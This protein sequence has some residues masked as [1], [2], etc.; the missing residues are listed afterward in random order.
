MT[1]ASNNVQIVRRIDGR[2]LRIDQI[3]SVGPR[4]N[5]PKCATR[6]S[7]GVGST[8]TA[9]N[10]AARQQRLLPL[11]RRR[12]VRFGLHRGTDPRPPLLL[13]GHRGHAVEARALRVRV[14]A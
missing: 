7:R 3:V 2:E 13:T 14:F 4:P 12:R 9:L 10:P 1:D 5:Y 11:L 8:T 6:I